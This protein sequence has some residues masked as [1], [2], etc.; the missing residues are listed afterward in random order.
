MEQKRNYEAQ[1]RYNAKTRRRY[2]LNLNTNTD[3]DILAHLETL[4]NVQ[5]YIKQ[6]IREDIARKKEEGRE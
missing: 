5:G 3:P 6:L 1:A 4:D 2:A